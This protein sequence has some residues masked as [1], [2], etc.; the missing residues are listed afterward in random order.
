MSGTTII[1]EKEWRQLDHF[2]KVKFSMAEHAAW[3]GANMA[4]PS[5]S[6]SWRG[7]SALAHSQ[8]SPGAPDPD[9][10][11]LPSQGVDFEARE[12]VL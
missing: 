2:A 3:R 4:K 6:D 8:T 5:M 10:D 1:C 12:I 7:H 11:C 9:T